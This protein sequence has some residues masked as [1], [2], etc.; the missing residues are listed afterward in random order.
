MGDPSRNWVVFWATR[1]CTDR[2][3]ASWPVGYHG[4]PSEGWMRES[5]PIVTAGHGL[6]YEWHSDKPSICWLYVCGPEQQT[7]ATKKVAACVW[8]GNPDN[9]VGWMAAGQGQCA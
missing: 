2:A 8:E 7:P 3:S 9:W 4:D 5:S 1:E 6:G